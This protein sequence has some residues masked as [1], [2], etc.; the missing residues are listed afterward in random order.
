[1]LITSVFVG[2]IVIGCAAWWFFSG[3]D[4]DWL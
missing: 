2:S 4:D 1:M 3:D